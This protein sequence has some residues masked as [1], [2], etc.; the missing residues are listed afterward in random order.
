MKKIVIPLI[1]FSLILGPVM[2]ANYSQSSKNDDINNNITLNNVVHLDTRYRSD[3]MIGDLQISGIS[4]VDSVDNIY[5][6]AV[7]TN[8]GLVGTDVGI[9][10]DW[11]LDNL[12]GNP[13]T[14]SFTVKAIAS[15]LA[16]TELSIPDVTSQISIEGLNTF[17]L[18]FYLVYEYYSKTEYGISIYIQHPDSFYHK[19]SN[20][21]IQTT[22]AI[23]NIMSLQIDS[24][25]AVS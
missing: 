17:T 16:N 21:W 13:T 7:L 25:N 18:S 6:D 2:Y 22:N 4:N 5:F 1:V 15:D 11:L 14:I 8:Q 19:I 12:Q 23:P 24:I 10:S 3:D 20:V 9:Y